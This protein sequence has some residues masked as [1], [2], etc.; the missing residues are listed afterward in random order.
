LG[1]LL[2]WCFK[3]KTICNPMYKMICSLSTE[4]FVIIFGGRKK[5]AR[6]RLLLGGS[7]VN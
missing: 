7:V 3:Y 1:L 5:A 2:G 4:M 6:R